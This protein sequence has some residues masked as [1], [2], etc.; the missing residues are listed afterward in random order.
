MKTATTI[1]SAATGSV[2]SSGKLKIF[3]LVLAFG[4]TTGSL[5]Y[6]HQIVEALN[7][8]EKEFADIYAKSLEYIANGK[9]TEGDYSFVFTEINNRIDFPIILSDK[10]NEVSYPYIQNIKNVDL[11]SSLSRERQHQYLHQLIVEM[12]SRHAPIV[13]AYQDTIVLARLHYGESKLVTNLRRLPYRLHQ[14][15][16]C[17]TERAKRYLGRYGA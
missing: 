6:T 9:A 8:K 2:S 7:K 11:D 5:W 17:E 4:I 16:L 12:D 3:L 14:L 13:V 15:Q 10:D 1:R